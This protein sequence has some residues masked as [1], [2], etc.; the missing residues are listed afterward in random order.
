[1][2]IVAGFARHDMRWIYGHSMELALVCV[3]LVLAPYGIYRIMTN[4]AIPLVQ[5]KKTV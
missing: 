2:S 1:M 3:S 5:H 4:P